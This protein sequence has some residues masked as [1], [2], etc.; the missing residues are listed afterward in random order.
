MLARRGWFAL[1]LLL[2]W[3]SLVLAQSYTFQ[4]YDKGIGNPNITCMLQDRTGYLWIGT[5]NGLFRYDGTA[6]QEFGRQDGLGGTA[7]VTLRQDAS[8]RLWVG[9]TEGL[10]YFGT[11]HRFEAVQY[12]GQAIDVR[13]GSALSPLPDGS[14]LAVAHR[15]LLQIN[16]APRTRSWDC[17]RFP[18]IDPSLPVWSVIANNDGSIVAGCGEA[19]CRMNGSNVTIWDTKNGLP[20][21][22]WSFLIRGTTGELWARGVNHIAVL[23][24]AESQF[25]TRDLP[26]LPGRSSYRTLAEDR[27]GEMLATLGSSLARYEDGGWRIFSQANGFGEDTVT[28][29]LIDREGL[30]WFGLLGHGLRRW[31]GYN[32]WEDWT[33]SNGL[34]NDVVWTILRDHK[35]RLWIGNERQIAYMERGQKTF[36][37]WSRPGIHCEKTYSLHESKDGSIWAATG[38]GYAIHIDEDTLQAQQYKLDNVVFSVVE[39]NPNLVW[40]ATTGGLFRGARTGAGWHFEHIVEP[41]LPEGAFF[42]LQR[43]AAN[44]L[45][46]V[47][48]DGIF[49]LNG[50]GWMRININPGRLGGHPRNISIDPSGYVWLDGG[51]P[52]AVRLQVR[53]SEVVGTRFFSKPQLAS[54]LVVAIAS[55]RRGWIWIGGDQGVDVFDGK[56]WRRYTTNDGLISNDISERAFWADPD[57]SEWIGTGAGLSHVLSPVVETAPPPPP[58]LNSV[59]YGTREL[60]DNKQTFDWNHKPLK[61]VFADLSFRGENSIRFRY[62][63]VGLDQEWVETSA[64]E[65]RYPELPARSYEFQVAAIDTS[66][67][68]RSDVRAFSFKILPPWWA[69]KPFI[70]ASVLLVLLFAKV[71]WRWRVQFLMARQHEL[72]RLVRERTDELDRRLIEQ[73]ELKKEAEQANQAKS[74]FLAIMSHEIRTPLNG[75]IGMTNLLQDTSLNQ[76]QREYTRTIHESADC[77][78]RIVGD[79]LD[80]SKIEANKLELESVEFELRQIVRDATSVVTGQIKRKSLK[81]K[82]D[83]DD[84][85]PAFVAGD[86]PRLK[87]ILLNLLSNAVKFTE[88]GSIQVLVLEQQRIEDDRVVVRFTVSDTGIGIAQD[89]QKSLFKSFS[90]A[91]TSISRRYGGTGL[92][93]AISKRLAEL[94]GGEIGVES[95]PGHGSRFWFTVN[96]PISRKSHPTMQGLGALQNAIANPNDSLPSRGRVL[97]AE[98]NLINQRVAAILLAKLGYSAD[99]AGDG[100]QAL[101]KLQQRD[102]DVVLMDCQMPVMDGFEATAAIRALGNG[103]SHIPII[104]VTAN[105]L[106]GQR[107]K[108]LAAGM[109]DYIPKPISREILENAIQKFLRSRDVAAQADVPFTLAQ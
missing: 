95:A 26:D 47:A 109:N 25:T 5:Q 97:V 58:I 53:G 40:A 81:L 77:L 55:D 69:T 85:L 59:Q 13:E 49:R 89:A 3:Q 11:N 61:I 87:Q 72:E 75:V 84:R 64:R 90:Q 18:G 101:E 38:A 80:F 4:S 52:G 76:E 30:V 67:G 100:K 79:V 83:F 24:P 94:M 105:A 7:I 99:L 44:H 74:D 37:S 35:D 14:L 96:L 56:N 108:C 12:Q 33:T 16:F 50:S 104:A 57:G 19:L 93:L 27:N 22:H 42:D 34:Q 92:G 68:K 2:S 1:S 21:D 43:D 15:G 46:A 48:K 106:T 31:I 60:L 8:G 88:N 51:F 107:E 66:T 82:I 103:R 45:W 91:E 36:Q 9:T 10:Y 78:T 32:Q 29:L 62:R 71:S 41:Q 28:S 17:R 6:F 86:A 98:D 65:V 54:D 63:L 20:A 39:E 70:G 73:Q 102:Y 23:M